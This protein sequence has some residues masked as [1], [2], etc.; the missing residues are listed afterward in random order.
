MTPSEW[1][2]L[3]SLALAWEW[4][5]ALAGVAGVGV[6]LVRKWVWPLLRGVG[7]FLRDW[8]GEPVRPGVKAKPG[9][10]EMLSELSSSQQAIAGNQVELEEQHRQLGRQIAEVR[11]E[12]TPNSGGSA[13]DK[14]S[15]EVR[16]VRDA[17]SQVLEAHAKQSAV[18]AFLLSALAE[19]HPSTTIPS[20]LHPTG[21]LRAQKRNRE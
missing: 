11:H 16:E 3:V 10:M 15:R 20:E 5:V 8:A 9:V 2:E 19:N 4:V 6:I 7:Y 21:G 1:S 14:L 12:V 18:D 13:H 17:L